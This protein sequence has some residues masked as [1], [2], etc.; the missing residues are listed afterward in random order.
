MSSF[1]SPSHRRQLKPKCRIFILQNVSKISIASS[2][3]AFYSYL[4]EVILFIWVAHRSRE[5]GKMR[6]GRTGESSTCS[7]GG[8]MHLNRR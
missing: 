6:S 3:S 4:S 7:K 2:F 1:V 8:E 5:E